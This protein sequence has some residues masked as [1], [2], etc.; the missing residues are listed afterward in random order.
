MVESDEEGGDVMRVKIVR[1]R[2]ICIAMPGINCELKRI[3][4][5]LK[6]TCE[7]L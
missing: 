6:T 7:G 2:S 3:Y 4:C 5:E 1:R